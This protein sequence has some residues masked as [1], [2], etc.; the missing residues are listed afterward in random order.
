MTK[1]FIRGVDVSAETLAREVIEK[2]GPGGH[3]LDQDHTFKHFRKEL[4]VPRLLTR[5]PYDIWREGGSKDMSQRVTERV[6]DILET[7][8]I[9]PL[10]DKTVAALEKTRNK[11]EKELIQMQA[12]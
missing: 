8:K 9:P 3:Y 2:V 5:Q 7:H 6:R 12:V 10:P 4:W 11:G 1:H